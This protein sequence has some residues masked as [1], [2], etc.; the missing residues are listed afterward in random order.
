M[1][2]LVNG[3]MRILHS[4]GWSSK[5]YDS[6]G[7]LP[8]LHRL[9]I[10]YLMLPVVIWLV[11]WFQWWLGIPA[12]LLL[13]FAFWKPLSGSWRVS[14]R[15]AIVV[16]AL[17]A[18]A[19]VL[20]T[21][22]GGVFDVH[23]FD[24]V[25]H[26]ALLLDLARGAWPVHLPPWDSDF[27]V[28][29]PSG[30]EPQGSL[31]RY[32]LGYYMVPGMVG[33]WLGLGALDWAVALWTWAGA[34]LLLLMFTQDL[35]GR[36]LVFAVVI[37]ILFSGMDVLRVV[38]EIAI[39]QLD[40]LNGQHSGLDVL[41]IILTESWRWID[42]GIRPIEWAGLPH[43]NAQMVA[44]MSS[45]MF[46]PQHFISAGLFTL[47]LL[48][49]RREPA[50]LAISGVLFAAAPFWSLFTAIGMLPL[51]AAVLWENGIRPFLRWPNLSLAVPLAGLIAIYLSSGSL[52]PQHGLLWERYGWSL[53]LVWVPVFYASEFLL[54][55]LI[56]FV[57]WP[58]LRR[59]PVFI[60]ALVSLSILPMYYL[61]NA[62]DFAM[63]ASLPA[64][65]VL[66]YYCARANLPQASG[67]PAERPSML[68]PIAIAGLVIILGLGAV[69]PI[70][71]LLQSSK[72]YVSGVMSY[73]ELGPEYSVLRKVPTELH[74]QYVAHD[75]PDWFRWLLR[76][77]DE[78][79]LGP[80]SK[81]E[82]II[83]STYTVYQDKRRL[84]YVK[85]PCGPEDVDTRFFLHVIPVDAVLLPPDRGH[86]SYD[87]EF[88]GYGWRVEG[89]C[90]AVREL[91][92]WDDVGHLTTGQFNP[93][94][95]KHSWLSRYFSQAFRSRL[96]D[97]AGE[98]AIRSSFEVYVHREKLEVEGSQPE[99]IQLLYLKTAC[100]QS[101][102]DA[103]FFLHVVPVDAKN[104][105]E[106]QRETG[107][108]KLDF[109]LDGFGGRSG[110]TCFAVRDLPD[111]GILEIRTGQY[112]AE[113]DKLWEGSFTLVD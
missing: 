92:N 79:P 1:D 61:S 23:N 75:I 29:I 30:Q 85:D 5:F 44:N 36:S 105:P 62:N 89:A 94:R 113:D 37:L 53:V 101:D 45:I 72:K 46:A 73:A 90:L 54:L 107:L 56:L 74:H 49:L 65:L 80:H 97:E 52:D 59:E 112:V 39:L 111:Y 109:S 71:N 40:S 58:G 32:Y 12:T 15:P 41:R 6:A 48:R 76:D 99:R 103:R 108:L 24:W 86:F 21:A 104:L 96:L 26:R 9:S 68:R 93:E 11:G 31:L 106:E 34:A 83:Q 47:L 2:G 42:R 69:T 66:C 18:L 110:K 7:E 95:T 16:V 20:A 88:R 78:D 13:V 38:Q 63:R 70:S 51:L 27:L 82:L 67:E 100:S 55:A 84:V 43:V 64:L 81:G 102:T 91:P 50:F 87:F 98:P 35:K 3:D 28:Y 8:L 25:K 19:W 17:I 60:A 10:L 77:R 4:R 14:L 57:L 22:A 33:K